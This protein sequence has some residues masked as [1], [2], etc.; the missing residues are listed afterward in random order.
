MLDLNF[1]QPLVCQDQEKFEA[2]WARVMEGK[3]NPIIVKKTKETTCTGTITPESSI[4]KEEKILCF[5][6][7]SAQTLLAQGISA[8]VKALEDMKK[9]EK[10]L[11]QSLK[12]QVV[13]LI[14][15]RKKQLNQLETAYF[16]LV[17]EDYRINHPETL[18]YI[19]P[20]P[21]PA[22]L[23]LRHLFR[24]AQ[25]WQAIYQKAAFSSFDSCLT[26]LFLQLESAL[27]EEVISLHTLVEAVFWL[28]HK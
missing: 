22:D 26:T 9:L 25:V 4:K 2:V 13:C 23:R 5:G 17:G 20:K 12:P 10:Q 14:T 21:V 27:K 8:Q 18:E 7:Q 16:L 6:E 11:P 28:R 19:H 15:Q 1:Q 3:P 24:E